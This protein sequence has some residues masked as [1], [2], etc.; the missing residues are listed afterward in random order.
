MIQN[1]VLETPEPAAS[2]LAVPDLLPPISGKDSRPFQGSLLPTGL[3][4]TVTLMVY[5]I[6]SDLESGA[7]AATN[8]M[9]EMVESG[10]D[11]GRTN[12]LVYTGGTP[13]WHSDVPSDANAVFLLEE[14]GFRQIEA[15]E[16]TSMGEADTLA[17]FLRYGYEQFPADM[18]DLILWDHGNGPVMGYGS[19]KVYGGDALTLPEIRAALEQSPFGK[20]KTAET[21]SAGSPE[22]D[23]A[24]SQAET[25]ADSQAET[26]ADSQ[27]ETN[28]GSQAETETPKLSFI[29]FDACLMASAELACTVAD[30]ADYL[31]ASQETEP[32]LGWNYAFLPEV[33]CLPARSLVSRIVDEYMTYCDAYFRDKE[34]FQSD[35][36]LAAVDLS[37]ARRLENAIDALFGEARDDVSGD[38]N[39]LAFARVH[40]HGFGRAST[41]SEYDLVDLESLLDGMDSRYPAAVEEVRSALKDAVVTSRASVDGCCGLSLFYPYYNK[42]YYTASWKESYAKIGL[43]PNYRS[44]LQRYEQIW[45]GTDL[46]EYFTEKMVPLKGSAPSTYTMQLTEEQHQQFAQAAYSILRRDGEDMYALVYKSN[47]VTDDGG[48]LKAR[49]DGNIIYIENDYGDKHIGTTRMMDTV[50]GVTDYTIFGVSAE[51]GYPYSDYDGDKKYASCNV[52]LAVDEET[53][54]VSVKG[55]F[56]KGDDELQTGKQMPVD[57]EEWDLF[58]YF[59]TYGRYLTRDEEGRILPYWD[60]PEGDWFSIAEMR[61]SMG[62]H[63]TYEPIYDDGEE[64]FIMFEVED[65]QGNKY[66]SELLPVTLAEAPAEELSV[67]EEFEWTEGNELTVYEKEGITISFILAEKAETGKQMYS[68]K[69]RNENAFP[70][71]LEMDDVRINERIAQTRMAYRYVDP[72]E[73]RCCELEN[74]AESARLAGDERIS[75]IELKLDLSRNDTHVY[76]EHGVQWKIHIPE[77]IQPEILT[78]PFMSAM[79]ERQNLKTEEGVLV[80][81]LELGEELDEDYSSTGTNGVLTASLRVTNNSDETRAAGVYGIELDGVFYAAFKEQTLGAGESWYPILEMSRQEIVNP[82]KFGFE[83]KHERIQ[84]ISSARLMLEID[85]KT[86]WCPVELKEHGAQEKIV[87]AGEVLFEDESM[88]IL[89]YELPGA[90]ADNV[91]TNDSSASATFDPSYEDVLDQIWYVWV[92]NKTEDLLNMGISRA[93]DENGYFLANGTVGAGSAGAW[94]VR[95]YPGDGDEDEQLNPRVILEYAKINGTRYTKTESFVL[96]QA[97]SLASG[98]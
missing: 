8:D 63:F 33:G 89:S 81:L 27:A 74:I 41:G 28:A 6:G 3:E 64:Y 87:P 98:R 79:A 23:T 36:T 83:A 21:A 32:S 91:D 68:V 62:M 7:A 88:K 82:V 44:Y 2:E 59:I 60:W 49:F 19:D 55:I 42:N 20:E 34:F 61:P 56:E 58:T 93:E 46:K 15:Y 48:F 25:A 45:L 11:F 35:V 76:L 90:A 47:Q 13:K 4:D 77:K 92:V 65:V 12:L 24:G 17:A 52:Q 22:K 16:Q 26:V 51:R 5:M 54:E 1:P 72:G 18:Y 73:T 75:S 40:A 39:K 57:P 9:T 84:N 37:Q 80:E 50:N 43:F 38:Y 10:I 94:K 29:G 53:G 96:P 71:S 31:V 97:C 70:I 67:P 66:E 86:L 95:V 69:I 14:G 85:G 30:Y 78:M